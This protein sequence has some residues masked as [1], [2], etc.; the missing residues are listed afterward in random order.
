MALIPPVAITVDDQARYGVIKVSRRMIAEM[1]KL[2]ENY[3]ILGMSTSGFAVV[4]EVYVQ[5]DEL[6]AV[7]EGCPP[8]TLSPIYQRNEDGTVSLLLIDK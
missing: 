8:P 5:S 7:C 1:L 3:K 2:P 6:D 4:L